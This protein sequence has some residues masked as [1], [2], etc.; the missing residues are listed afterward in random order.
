VAV[1]GA[2]V[3]LDDEALV[4]PE[5]VDLVAGDVL[6]DLRSWEAVALDEAEEP[7][8]EAGAGWAGCV[9]FVTREVA[10]ARFV[11]CA[12]EGVAGQDA[13]QVLAGADGSGDRDAVV[14]GDCRRG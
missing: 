13:C 2:A 12:G 4:S 6:V 7:V 5:H 10:D 14:D 3:E 11:D 9:A 8:L 1:E